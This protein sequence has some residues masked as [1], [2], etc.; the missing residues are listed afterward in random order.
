[1]TASRQRQRGVSL[2]IV[3]V[4][5]LLTMLMTVWASKTAL[6]NELIVGNDADYQRAFEAAQA[7]LQDAEQ[8]IL[9]QNVDGSACAPSASDTK[10][11]RRAGNVW[12]ID[13]EK[14]FVGL[15]ATLEAA[16]NVP[17]LNGICAKR[18]GKQD[19]WNDKD[20]F[21]QMRA[22]GVA[23]RYGEYTGAQKGSYSNP[24]LQASADGTGAWYW[25]EVMP[26]ASSAGA[27]ITNNPRAEQL[28]LNLNPPL[29][30][31]ITAIAQG[32]RSGTQVVLQATLARQKI[33]D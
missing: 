20:L 18:T 29:V 12:F 23:A 22:A 13:E 25:V 11:C 6:L 4:I 24:I 16:A 5:V 9:G 33:K 3:I 19:F 7:M 1:M 26:Y 15:L 2:L 31:R 21:P 30:Y 10:I 28:V 17:C 14:D 27:L 8:D 32:L